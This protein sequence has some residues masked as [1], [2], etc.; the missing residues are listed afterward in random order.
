[1]ECEVGF[2]RLE[3]LA[4]EVGCE[5]TVQKYAEKANALVRQ[6]RLKLVVTGMRNSG[7]TTLINRMLES[8]VAE[9]SMLSDEN[10]PPLR[11]DF[12][13]MPDD[14]NY[15]CVTI[16]NR[17]WDE[18]LTI[19]YEL[20]VQNVFQNGML[21]AEM[22]DKDVVLFLISAAAPFNSDEIAILK[23]LA[24]LH[25]QVVLGG[26][27]YVDRGSLEKVLEYV[28]KINNS[29]DL[30]PVLV[31][32]NKASQD[33]GHI[34]RNL[35]PADEELQKMRR[36]HCDALFTQAVAETRQAIETAKQK[37]AAEME[38]LAESG[39]K[40][41]GEATRMQAGWETLLADSRRRQTR[42]AAEATSDLDVEGRQIVQS[43]V[44]SGQKAMFSEAWAHGVGKEVEH[45]VVGN[46]ERRIG[47]LK[48]M[49]LRD[50]QKV[51]TDAGFLKLDGYVVSDFQALEKNAPDHAAFS[52]RIFG[53]MLGEADGAKKNGGELR[54]LLGTGM[55][56]GVV[57]LSPLP[58]LVK[59]LGGA[60]LVAGGSEITRRQVMSEREASVK[61]ALGSWFQ[62]YT[63][64]M[65]KSLSEAAQLCYTGLLELL[66]SCHDNVKAKTVDLTPLKER[67]ARISSLLDACEQM[68]SDSFC[69]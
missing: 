58:L 5:T 51:S 7:K 59:V 6:E 26:I 4:Q 31:F 29:L 66:Q 42:A 13:R 60:T 14:P 25:R 47:V 41:I 15:R 44:E 67:E 16:I 11:V 68:K 52:P 40:L 8:T 27:D 33:I 55:A 3:E 32:E 1:M 30:P 56:V 18:Q 39:Q 63:T 43:I 10:E 36:L 23:A 46:F 62:T 53:M 28:N 49:Y 37:T 35:L 19:L 34:V 45:I 54:I 2:Q 21:T 20:H 61:M 22:D 48:E 24:P 38:E 50:L 57:A 69:E 12:E 17:K 64:A 9:E 65:E